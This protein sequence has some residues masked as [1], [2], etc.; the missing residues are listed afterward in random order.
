ME[1]SVAVDRGRKGC[2]VCG[3]W[4]DYAL[5]IVCMGVCVLAEWRGHCAH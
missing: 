5:Y 2:V 1:F 3:S 4:C